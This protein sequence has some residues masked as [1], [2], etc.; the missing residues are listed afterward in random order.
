MSRLYA[1]MFYAR[2]DINALLITLSSFL[3]ESEKMAILLNDGRMMNLN[4][5][6]FA[7]ATCQTSCLTEKIDDAHPTAQEHKIIMWRK[8]FVDVCNNI[9]RAT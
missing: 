1:T 8:S 7:S 6:M 5:E 3:V 9:F 4:D 2:N